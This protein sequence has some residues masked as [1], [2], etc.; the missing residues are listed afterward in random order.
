MRASLSLSRNLTYFVGE[1]ENVAHIRNAGHLLVPKQVHPAQDLWRGLNILKTH[2]DSAGQGWV[3]Y[4]CIRAL[5]ADK[6]PKLALNNNMWLG[7]PPLVLCKLTFAESLLIARHYARCYVF[8][9]YPKEGSRGCHPAHLQRA[10]AGNVTLY[11]V[12][13]SAIA[14]MLEGEILPQSVSALSSIIAVT[15]IGTHQLP[16][17]WLSRTFTVRRSAVHEALQWL[18][19]HNHLYQ[20]VVI[21]QDR[22]TLLPDNEIPQEIEALMRYEDDENLAV[23]EREGYVMTGMEEGN[24]EHLIHQK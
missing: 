23:K 12:N 20:D 1:L 8:K 6:M 16:K 13:T 15:F 19:K 7:T 21:S 4:E 9:L 17:D 14:S 10:M 18:H 5:R 3:C 24:G 22:L 2:V 11:D